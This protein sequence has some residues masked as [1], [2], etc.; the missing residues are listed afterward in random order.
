M[1][2]ELSDAKSQM[3]EVGPW[4]NEKLDALENYL[5]YYTKR[6]KNQSQWKTI[7]LDAFAGGGRA[8]IR[9]K[10][11]V[12]SPQAMLWDDEPEAPEQT[13]FVRGSPR[14]ALEIAN[15]FDSYIFIDAD[16]TRV[17]MLE[18]LKKE[19]AGRRRISVRE[20]TADE[21]ISWVL[22]HRPDKRRHRGI[23]FLDP[24]GAHLAWTSIETLARTGLF[25][26]IIN[27]P[28]HM[29]L[30]RL[31]T[32]DPEI[33]ESWREQ[34]EGFL[35]PGWYDQVYETVSTLLGQETRKRG[36]ALEAL[37]IWYSDKLQNT[38]GFVSQPRLIKN[39]RGGPLYY[40]LWAGPNEAGLK[41]ANYIM[42]MGEKLPRRRLW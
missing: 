40:L 5:D 10:V 4:A 33:R 18:G 9:K 6:L 20:G 36:D 7:Y 34:L 2:E 31:M 8:V 21:Q 35:P 37:L 16:P 30:N 12:E 26:V 13:A 27:F 3:A 17:E 23:A 28:L 25:E 32:R 38:F 42:R 41:G 39:T 29:C 19:F 11:K 15:P 1:M 24:F 14:R 22:S